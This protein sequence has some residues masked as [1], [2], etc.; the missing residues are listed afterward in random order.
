MASEGAG[1]LAG[2]RLD[3]RIGDP[4]F[5]ASADTTRKLDQG[6]ARLEQEFQTIESRR[7][8]LEALLDSMQEAVIAVDAQ[9]RVHWSNAVMERVVERI[10]APVRIG[11]S[12]VQA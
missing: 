11:R 8:E 4:G 7:R 2:G 3:A 9:G 1:S 5:S 10:A 6:M 12:L